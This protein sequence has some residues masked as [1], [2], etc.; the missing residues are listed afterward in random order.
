M[1]AYIKILR[2]AQWLK[3]LMLL[4]PPFLGGTLLKQGMASQAVLP[5]TAFCLASSATYIFNDIRDADCDA[6]H[7]QKSR[8]P[9]PAGQI[10]K[11][12]AAVF[13]TA[14]LGA[15]VVLGSWVSKTFLL[16]LLAYLAVSTAYSIGLKSQPIVDI[17]CIAAGF[18]LRLQAGGAAF[19]VTISDWLF[20][21]VFLLAIFLS[22]GKRLCERNTL[23][24]NGG[25]HRE[26]L[27][28]YPPGL[29]EGTTRLIARIA[30]GRGVTVTGIPQRAT[31][32]TPAFVI[33]PWLLLVILI[34]FLVLMN[35]GGGGRRSPP[36]SR[37]RA[38]SAR[39]RSTR[40]RTSPSCGR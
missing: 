10:S 12:V 20:L 28:H 26:S 21:S 17:F 9:I 34:I 2:P 19:G 15:A 1:I 7:P 6:L 40:R 37:S 13:A 38:R 24:D 18:V 29:L 27:H 25:N 32:D 3:N 31:D 22:T 5:L 4:F 33:S 30:Q 39:G 11:S 35:S 16:L 14:V 36:P 23:G 8:R